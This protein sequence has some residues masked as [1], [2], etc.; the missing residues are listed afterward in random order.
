MHFPIGQVCIIPI[1]NDQTPESMDL[2][3]QEN[4]NSK[5]D[6]HAP[7]AADP[8]EIHPI[9]TQKTKK[10]QDRLVGVPPDQWPPVQMHLHV[11]AWP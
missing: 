11:A 2:V 10:I 5:L 7:L 3:D 8:L 1:D 9:I 4:K 6:L